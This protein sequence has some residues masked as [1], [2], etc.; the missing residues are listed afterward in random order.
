MNSDEA[1]IS[2][3]LHLW[4]ERT[5]LG[6]QDEVLANHDENVVIFDVLPPMQYNGTKAYRDSWAEWQ[7]ETVGDSI[8]ELKDLRVTASDKVGFAFSQIHC[9]GRLPDG[10]TFEDNVRATFCLVKSDT[11]W[12]IV[13][14]HGSMPKS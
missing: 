13:H 8:F 7:P 2:K 10:K 1:D 14:Q 5:R 6:L 4:A 3:L 11:G 9:G 12:K